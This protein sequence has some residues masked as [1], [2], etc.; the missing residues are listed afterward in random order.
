VPSTSLP[1][2]RLRIALATG[3]CL[4]CVAL[5]WGEARAIST[6]IAPTGQAEGDEFGSFVA[7]A[8]DVNGDGYA[9][10]IVGS[11]LNDAAGFNVGRAYVYYGGPGSDEVADLTLTGFGVAEQFGISVGTA[12]DV[13]GDGYADVIVGAWFSDAGGSHAGRAYVY[14][15]GPGADDVPEMILTGAAAGDLFGFWVA[16]AGDVNGDGAAD[17]IVGA[18][19]NDAG[20]TTAGQAYVFYGGPGADATADLTFTGAAAFDTFGGSVGAAG[21]VNG[22]GYADVI[23]GAQNNDS[24]G[25]DAGRAYVYYGGPEADAVADLVLTGAAGGDNFG[26][27]VGT[28]GDVNGDGFAD[29]IVGAY[30]SDAGR[31]DAGRAYVF[32][33]GPGADPVAD[34]VLTGGAPSDFFGYSVG[35]AG[36]VDGDGFADVIIGAYNSDAGEAD[37]GKAYIYYGSLS[38]D[39]VA[40]LV[41]TGEAG[42]DNFGRSVGTAGDAT[43]DGWADVIVGAY[44]NDA[45]GV[46]AGRAYVMT[47]SLFGPRTDYVTGPSPR[48]VAIGDFNGDGRPD[49]VA[50]DFGGNEVSVFLGNGDGTFGPKAEFPTG[51][52]PTSVAIGDFNGDGR[53]DLATADFSFMVSV[54]LGTG[55]GAFGP[56]T[57]HPAGSNPR[58]VAVGDLNGDGTLDLVV[59]NSG[60]NTVSA[61]LGDGGGGFGPAIHT[62]TEAYPNSIGIKNFNGDPWPDL[63]VANRFSNTISVLLGLGNGSFAFA[64]S[65]VTALLPFSVAVGHLN[66]DTVWDLAVANQGNSSVSV[67]FGSGGG[68]FLP[69][70]DFGAGAGPA[71]VAIGDFNGDGRNDLAVANSVSNTVSVLLALGEGTFADKI[72][73]ATGLA[74]WSVAVGD[75]NGD[76]RPDLVVAN[77]SSNSVSVLLNQGGA[78]VS[79]LA[80]VLVA[81]ISMNCEEGGTLSISVTAS[82]PDGE[83]ITSLSADLSG[84][85]AGNDAIFTVNASNTAGTLTWHPVPGDAGTYNV[86]FTASSPNGLAGTAAT[87]IDVAF[88]GTSITGRFLW[89]PSQ[90]DAGVYDVVF[91]ATDTFGQTDTAVTHVTVTGGAGMSFSPP[92]RARKAA[93]IATKGP[94]IRAVSNVE[95]TAGT[96]AVIDVSASGGADALETDTSDLPAD[97]TATF[98]TDQEPVVAAPGMVSG[99]QGSQISVPVTAADPEGDGITSLTVDLSSLPPGHNAVFTPN[100]TNTAGTLTWTPTSADSGNYG[101]T[102]SASNALVGMAPTVISVGDRL[103]AY[104][105][106]NGNGADG[107][108]GNSLTAVG[109]VGYA[110][111]RLNLAADLNGAASGRLEAPALDRYDLLAAGF[112][113]ECWVQPRSLAFAPDPIIA[114]ANNAGGAEAWELLV[115]GSSCTSGNAGVRIHQSGSVTELFSS[116]TIFNGQF[117]HVAVTYDGA[118][119]K[120]YID[121]VLDNSVSAPGL[122]AHVGGGT[123]LLGNGSGGTGQ[124]DGLIDEFRI[125]KMARSGSQILN[126]MNA[127]LG[128]PTAVEGPE[129]PRFSFA[130]FQN[131][132]NPFN[133]STLIRFELAEASRARLYVYDV[134]GRTVARLVD[135]ELPAGRHL[136]PWPGRDGG[137]PTVA[138]GVYFYRLEAGS[139]TSTRRMVLLR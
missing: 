128:F 42:G 28:A 21:D 18:T 123:I 109:G 120:L 48:S 89:T 116:R 82:D 106:L 119:L 47:A 93:S 85:P 72:D 43:G 84:L 60:S 110:P 66:G 59:A 40:D 74:P 125:W 79:N 45:T 87:Q 2:K 51:P 70:Q 24:G 36:D 23:V 91:T 131:R 9:D 25:T 61:L 64:G 114:R 67:L 133:P 75:L 102:F 124:F 31:V 3:F 97:N 8:G 132:P 139:F 78:A 4:A 108:G 12:G 105:K 10:V 129:G 111:G 6:L 20:G 56:Q 94:V 107:A 68:D 86:T 69:R 71:S 101:V 92:S 14:H 103:S 98:S 46:N 99:E 117:H 88:P 126:G 73:F 62:G 38:P 54:L 34:L 1:S 44:R 49:L 37:A 29:V 7:T 122:M 135:R 32:Y 58:S 100:P 137:R 41:L 127:E 5:A 134:H 35:T 13:N 138:S 112:T 76:G 136:V 50:A 77:E 26:R 130:L 22:D 65:H 55:D 39:A 118:N 11:P 30:L 80:P 27:S 16:A 90:S 57:F 115:C 63:A 83:A 104:W 53:R 95:A 15:G 81:P 113:A 33:G 121:G 17:V 96:T 52:N 19:G